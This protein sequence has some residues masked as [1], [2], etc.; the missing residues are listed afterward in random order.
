MIPSE[1]IRFLDTGLTSGHV[2]AEIAARLVE[3]GSRELDMRQSWA[4]KRGETVHIVTGGTVVA[5]RAGTAGPEEASIVIGAAHTDSPGLQLKDR[6]AKITDGF[7]QVPVEV[8][9]GPI[10]ATWIDRNLAI[11]GR[12]AVKN[13]EAG[14][15]EVRLFSTRR[16]WAV[17]PNLAIHFNREVNESL[18]YNRQDHLKALI[19]IDASAAPGDVD[20]DIDGQTYFR[21]MVAEAAGISP[22]DLVD[23]EL[24]LVSA[25]AASFI[26][27][28]QDM[29]TSGRIDNLAGC[30]AVLDG[31]TGAASVETA[32]SAMAIFYDHEEI[33]STTAFGAAGDITRHTLTRF[34]KALHGGSVDMEAVLSR[35]VLL[36]NDCA[37]GR[38]PN[39][40]DKHDPGY[41]PLLGRGPVI[42]KSA[43]RR[44]ATELEPSAWFASVCDERGVP[45]QYLQNRSDITAGSTIGPAVASRLSVP[46]VDIG[47]PM[48]A[49]H[50]IRE[51]AAL[52]DITSM[53]R[54]LEELFKR[55]YR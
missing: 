23:M 37:H 28:G 46:S 51:T 2:S 7:V 8:Y 39:Y 36:S 9:G 1:M 11:A 38:H 41:A 48:L 49:M 18:S 16:P 24:Q 4:I 32:H 30:I 34:L 19:P 20:G 55:G 14:V 45:L 43:V 26:G 40:A 35:S 3:S 22:D 33:G 5:F 44:Y 27:R 29:V 25:E 21:T 53:G 15:P 13:A 54:V 50:S 17:I 10:L 42:K 47:I 12:I 31:F 6:S 52:S